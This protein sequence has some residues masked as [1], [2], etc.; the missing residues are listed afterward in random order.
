M[1]Y[2]TGY[3][4]LPACC[5]RQPCL[6]VSKIYADSSFADSLAVR[7]DK[8]KKSLRADPFGQ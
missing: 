1:L 3:L 7:T 4:V 6:S 2:V 8:P 5:D